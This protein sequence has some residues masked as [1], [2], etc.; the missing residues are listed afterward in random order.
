MERN[1]VMCLKQ[2]KNLKIFFVNCLI[3]SVFRHSFPSSPCLFR[4]CDFTCLQ[5]CN[6]L[7]SSVSGSVNMCSKYIICT[8]RENKVKRDPLMG[9]QF[10]NLPLI[11]LGDL[12]GHA[13]TFTFFFRNQS[14]VT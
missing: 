9:L 1:T 10:K 7:N 13:R 2:N 3:S 5:I 4:V 8:T 14:S 12:L 11:K 6:D